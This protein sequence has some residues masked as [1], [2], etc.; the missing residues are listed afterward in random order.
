MWETHESS[1]EDTLSY[2]IKTFFSHETPRGF[3]PNS[4]THASYHVARINRLQSNAASCL[5][6]FTSSFIKNTNTHVTHNR[7]TQ[8]YTLFSQH[9][10]IETHFFHKTNICRR[11][12]N[13]LRTKMFFQRRLWSQHYTRWQNAVIKPHETHTTG[14]CDVTEHQCS[15]RIKS[16][17]TWDQMIS[18]ASII[19]II[20]NI[21]LTHSHQ[22]EQNLQSMTN[23]S[24]S[25]RQSSKA[26]QKTWKHKTEVFLTLC[27]LAQYCKNKSDV[28][29]STW[30]ACDHHTSCV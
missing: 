7:H 8:H 6:S 26:S 11:P 24:N 21:Y 10:L 13:E 12:V 9:L 14:A 27:S 17:L 4:P 22:I 29:T 16:V 30:D 28:C 18:S 15:E 3:N 23:P 19:I 20:C 2:H 25:T 1:S 5:F